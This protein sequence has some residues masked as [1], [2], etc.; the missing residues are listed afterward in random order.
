MTE[1]HTVPDDQE[2]SIYGSPVSVWMTAEH[3][4][5]ES[6]RNS[7]DIQDIKIVI[8]KAIH[9]AVMA[10]RD[11]Q[12]QPIETAPHEELVVLGWSEDGVWKQE[13]ALASAGD[14]YPN[15]YSNRWLHGRATHWMPLP[16]APKAE[17]E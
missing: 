12:W 14:R 4:A 2:K 1:S 8:A 16:A 11:K 15:G 7:E 3:V 9:D 17:G 5:V 10:E 13:I 6:Y